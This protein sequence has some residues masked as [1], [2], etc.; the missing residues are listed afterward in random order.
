MKDTSKM[1]AWG[2]ERIEEKFL[3]QTRTVS[4]WAW[5]TDPN[6]CAAA[7]VMLSTDPPCISTSPPQGPPVDSDYT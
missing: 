5:G 4:D 1:S 6:A 7:L 2:V 3:G